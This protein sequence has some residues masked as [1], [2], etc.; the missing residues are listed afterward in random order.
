MI[1]FITMFSYKKTF[2]HFF[3]DWVYL[4]DFNNQN[5]AKHVQ[6]VSVPEDMPPLAFG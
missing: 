5:F 1:Y 3:I 4:L 6:K 2:F